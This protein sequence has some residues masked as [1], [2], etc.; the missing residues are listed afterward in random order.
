MVRLMLLLNWVCEQH[1]YSGIHRLAS[2]ALTVLRDA[3]FFNY[4]VVFLFAHLSIDL[5]E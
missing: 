1:N 3:T 2:I 5:F 4:L